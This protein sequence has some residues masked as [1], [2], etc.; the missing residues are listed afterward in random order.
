MNSDEEVEQN[1]IKDDDEDEENLGSQ[2]L[3]V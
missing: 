1:L 2:F 3:A